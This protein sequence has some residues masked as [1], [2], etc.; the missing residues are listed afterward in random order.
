MSDKTIDP[1]TKLC[2]AKLELLESILFNTQ[3]L[4][5]SLRFHAEYLV[6]N[7]KYKNQSQ[8][9]TYTLTEEEFKGVIKI[10]EATGSESKMHLISCIAEQ[11]LLEISIKEKIYKSL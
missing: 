1:E 11:Y 4:L 10:L 3:S 7:L 5:G 2:K 8:D 6:R 9:K